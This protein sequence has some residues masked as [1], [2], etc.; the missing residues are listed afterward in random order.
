MREIW[1]AMASLIFF[2]GGDKKAS[3]LIQHG[4]TYNQQIANGQLVSQRTTLHDIDND[5]DLDAFVCNDEGASLLYKTGATACWRM[6]KKFKDFL[7]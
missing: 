1:M 7:N 4:R 3:A 2:L 5:G 6:V